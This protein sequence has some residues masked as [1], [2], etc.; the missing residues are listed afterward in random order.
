MPLLLVTVK[1][2]GFRRSGQAWKG[3]TVIDSEQ[4]TEDQLRAIA[5]DPEFTIGELPDNFDIADLPGDDITDLRKKAESKITADETDTL[6]DSLVEAIGELE[7]GNAEHWTQGGKP[8][9]KALVKLTGIKAIT[10][11]Q[12]DEAFE[13]YQAEA[14][15]D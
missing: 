9:I 2:D 7:T 12:R 6:I 15:N 13:K 4:F 3:R 1:H 14:G 5:L 8:E 11:K 10:G